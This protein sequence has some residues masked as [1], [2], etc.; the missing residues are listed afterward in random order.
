MEKS[1]YPRGKAVDAKLNEKFHAAA[2]E[3]LVEEL[4]TLT[5]SENVKSVKRLKAIAQ[6]CVNT[7]RELQVEFKDSKSA[8]EKAFGR[9]IGILSQMI[10]VK[11]HQLKKVVVKTLIG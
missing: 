2:Q 8:D 9:T 7:F 3:L 1:N 5:P 6:M 11:N 4:K 10:G